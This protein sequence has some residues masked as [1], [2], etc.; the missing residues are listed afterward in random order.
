[1]KRLKSLR[2][3]KSSSE[4]HIDHS[5]AI[6]ASSFI[7]LSPE[8]RLLIY[9]YAFTRTPTEHFQARHHG[10]QANS[11]SGLMLACRQIRCEVEEFYY[12]D[13]VVN[14]WPHLFK[15]GQDRGRTS[16]SIPPVMNAWRNSRHGLQLKHHPE[17]VR[18]LSLLL[19]L[20]REENAMCHDYV[21]NQ[22]LKNPLLK[23]TDLYLQV[24]I[25][26]SLQW[27]HDNPFSTMAFCIALEVFANHFPTLQRIHILYC[28]QRWPKWLNSDESDV[29]FP[30]FVLA[31]HTVRMF[32]GAN[33]N[34]QRVNERTRSW[35]P[36]TQRHPA[37]LQ[38]PA[39][40]SVVEESST[41][42]AEACKLRTLMTWNYTNVHPGDNVMQVPWKERRVDIDYYDSRTVLGVE[43]VHDKPPRAQLE[44]T[45]TAA[46]AT[47]LTRERSSVYKGAKKVKD[48]VESWHLGPEWLDHRPREGGPGE[49]GSHSRYQTRR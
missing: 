28:G 6:Q 14:L 41:D 48:F 45:A 29:P 39:Q 18:R 8:L 5:L 1:M 27:L 25:C 4:D 7:R 16:A 31:R 30:D 37:H 10:P 49:S 35:A 11:A 22:I 23:P 19:N 33:W 2:I 3:F 46:Q 40:M 21:D 44:D 24:C 47:R 12:K 32:S 36:T 26:R 17:Q 15:D 34:V 9:Q 20:T 38:P 43:C 13:A 42:E